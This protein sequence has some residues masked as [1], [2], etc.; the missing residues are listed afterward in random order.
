MS[1]QDAFHSDAIKSLR[2]EFL[3]GGK[4]AICNVCWK[5]EERGVSSIRTH[6]IKRFKKQFLLEYLQTPAITSIDIKFNNTCNFKCRICAPNSSSLYA[7]E[8]HK[9]S[10]MPLTTQSKWSES[11][12]FLQQIIEILPS[13]TFI[14]MYGGEPFLIKKFTK[15]L[16]IAIEQGYAKNIRLHYNSNGSIWPEEFIPYWKHFK[17]IDIHF[18]VKFK[19]S[20]HDYFLD[21]NY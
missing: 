1:C 16:Q 17:E 13:L 10:G 21:A 14:D 11:D 9:F 19:L 2:Q 6:N 3:A 8:R 5:N 20:K 12:E 4:P 15:V 7:I 18:S